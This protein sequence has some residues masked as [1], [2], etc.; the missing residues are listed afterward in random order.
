MEA[1]YRMKPGEINSA[2]VQALVKIFGTDEVSITI[3]LGSEGPH[4]K[5][6]EPE[7]ENPLTVDMVH[8]PSVNMMSKES[9]ERSIIRVEL[10]NKQALGIL[11]SLE[12][13]KMIRLLLT[14]ADSGESPA[15]Y[16][17]LFTKERA[18]ELANEIEN[19]R[20]EWKTRI[21]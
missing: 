11:K 21:I 17:G 9:D 18:F 13:A 14:S 6:D 3:T 16:K 7:Q 4:Y 10:K 20:D 12:Q 8:E 19:S 15:Q 2:F 1:K 5:P